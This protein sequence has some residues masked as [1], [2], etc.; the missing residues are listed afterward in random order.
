MI[1]IKHLEGNIFS[2]TASGTLSESDYEMLKPRLEQ[3]AE[4]HGEVRLVWEMRD[5]EGWQPGALLEDAKLDI[6][7]NSRV[8]KLA[9][10]GEARWQ[11]W[12]TQLSKPFA[13]GELRYFDM[14]ERGA[15][16][17][18]IRGNSK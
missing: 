12:I 16:Y 3:E 17:A 7:L 11:N 5:V 18:W 4:R 1:D 9:I 6:Q 10:I 8:S 14:G 13:S 15:A 2:V